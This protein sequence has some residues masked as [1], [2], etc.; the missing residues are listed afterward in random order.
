[1]RF[2]CA[3]TCALRGGAG[4]RAG[5]S[6]LIMPRRCVHGLWV[7]QPSPLKTH[8][9][10]CWPSCKMWPRVRQARPGGLARLGQGMG[11]GMGGGLAQSIA[12]KETRHRTQALDGPT[13]LPLH[14]PHITHFLTLP[15][16]S[17]GHL[18]HSSQA[19]NTCTPRA[20]STRTSSPKTSCS[21]WA[22]AWLRSWSAEHPSPRVHVCLF[23]HVCVLVHACGRGVV[24]PWLKNWQEPF[25]PLSPLG[26]ISH[27]HA[28]GPWLRLTGVL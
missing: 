20:S 19:W 13:P 16:Y 23:A 2:L 10:R 9:R 1:M 18:S 8:A 28:A 4:A 22:H 7:P 26:T 27:A 11:M 24:G 12:V 21:R 5:H 14:S 6:L 15:L 25:F 3:C 17:C